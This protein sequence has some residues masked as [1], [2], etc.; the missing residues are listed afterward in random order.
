MRLPNGLHEHHLALI[1]PVLTPRLN[2]I[3]RPPIYQLFPGQQF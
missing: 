1:F 2:L 3:S